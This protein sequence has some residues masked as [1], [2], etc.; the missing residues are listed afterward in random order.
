M[1]FIMQK[2]LHENLPFASETVTQINLR[3]LFLLRHGKAFCRREALVSINPPV[4]EVAAESFL[5]TTG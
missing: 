4:Y 2:F 1:N 5:P 3:W